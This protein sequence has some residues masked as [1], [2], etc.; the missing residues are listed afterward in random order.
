MENLELDWKALAIKCEEA[1]FSDRKLDAY[2]YALATNHIDP[3]SFFENF[4]TEM[5]IMTMVP[6]YTSSLDAIKH[7]ISGNFSDAYYTTSGY[8]RSS[9]HV[10]KIYNYRYEG[11][12]I[13]KT[14]ELARCAAFCCMMA[15][16][17]TDANT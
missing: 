6:C 4:E 11:I 9:G 3:K 7:L 5:S 13:G 17:N 8:I 14:E 2:I 15:R 1:P 16:K 12:G 10:F